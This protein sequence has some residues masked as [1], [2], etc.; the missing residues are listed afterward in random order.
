MKLQGAHSV[1]PADIIVREAEQRMAEAIMPPERRTV[2]EWVESED[3][4]VLS[5]RTSGI[6]GKL[7]L[8]VTPYLR[9]P[10]D[11]FSNDEIERIALCFGTQSGKTTFLQCCIG[12]TVDNDPG[13]TMFVRPTMSDATDFSNDRM[14]PFLLDCPATMQHVIGKIEDRIRTLEY[15][16]DRMTLRYAWSQSEV[17]VRGHPIRYL[18]KDETSAFAPGASALAD[19]RTKTYWNRKIIETSTP[20]QEEDTIWRFLG[21]K[22]ASEIPENEMLNSTAYQP[23]SST[24]VYYY[25]IPCPHCNEFIRL[26]ISQIRWPEDC[27]LRDIDMLGWYEC[28]HCKKKIT[29]ADK[30]RALEQG[31]WLTD[32]PGGRWIGYHLNSLYAPWASCRFGAIAAEYIKARRSNDYEV[33]KSFVNNW[34]ALPYSLEDLG[35][36][37]ITLTSIENSR[38]RPFRKNELVPEIKAL[39]IGADVQGDRIYWVVLGWSATEEITDGLVERQLK[40]HVVSWGQAADFSEFYDSV[41]GYKWNHPTHGPMQPAC[42]AVDGRYRSGEVKAFVTKYPHISYILGERNVRSA[43]TKNILPFRATHIDRDSKGRAAMNSKIGYRINTVYWKQWLYRR[44]SVIGDATVF[45]LPQEDNHDTRA[46]IRHLSSEVEVAERKK[47]STAIERV[48]KVRKG[49]EANHWLDATVY[50]SAIANIKGLFQLTGESKPLGVESSKPQPREPDKKRRQSIFGG[51]MN[52]RR[53]I[54]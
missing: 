36:N 17:S 44:I 5:E 11:A 15:R 20:S 9:G 46:Y 40:T 38:M 22:R 1:K 49:Y 52:V 48:W 33:M 29:D 10:L 24:T 3:G 26:E 41:V 32:N 25:H 2:T 35:A 51:A 42:G 34:L 47:G 28:Q 18:F 12:F 23:Q 14:I 31:Q 19:E 6:A 53:T 43:G 13:P 27:A 30:S 54:R 50:A 39:T 8:D 4:P 37:V 45:H 16:F 21:L 7:S